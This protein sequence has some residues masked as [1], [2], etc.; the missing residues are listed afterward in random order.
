MDSVSVTS[1]KSAPPV[2]STFR[3]ALKVDSRNEA[4]WVTSYDNYPPMDA[5]AN[6]RSFNSKL[7]EVVI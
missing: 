7:L 3:E 1:F 4:N 2:F 6:T 5:T